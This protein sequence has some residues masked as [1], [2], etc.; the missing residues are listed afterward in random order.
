[1][2]K[3]KS[4][5]DDITS[6]GKTSDGLPYSQMLTGTKPPATPLLQTIRE[7]DLRDR[8]EFDR[9]GGSSATFED[10]PCPRQDLTFDDAQKTFR[11]IGV[12][13]SDKRLEEWHVTGPSQTFTNLALLL[14]DQCPYLTKCAVFASDT[15]TNLLDHHECGGS[16]VSQI[17]RTLSYIVGRC[18]ESWPVPA[19]QEALVNALV[20]RDY[21]YSGPTIVNQFAS[22]IEVISLGGLVH[23]LEVND[24][25]NGISQ[26]RNPHLA[27]ILSMLGLCNNYGIGI[28]HI[29]DIYE[30]NETSPQL[31]VGPS[32]VA[33]ILPKTMPLNRGTPYTDGTE[34]TRHD[35]PSSPE[36]A[37][38]PPTAQRYIFPSPTQSVTHDHALALTGMRVIGCAPLQ[39]AFLGHGCAD[40]ERD[41]ARPL[42]DATQP[43]PVHTLEQITLHYLASAGVPLTRAQ[44][45]RNLGVNKNQAAHLLRQLT[46]QGKVRMEGQSRATLYSLP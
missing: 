11:H 35:D 3:Q 2:S 20:H 26:A 23:G 18:G 13:W 46:R 14:S 9:P 15:K 19:V 8:D 25:L 16:V 21:N 7:M 39:V 4:P 33:V 1:M 34:S 12:E 40:P 36:A 30:D 29:M 28:Q 17:R 42:A 31:C 44:I 5:G 43:Y 22:R 37:L 45:Q 41:G 38:H 24:L 32:S 27:Q 10:R 6:S